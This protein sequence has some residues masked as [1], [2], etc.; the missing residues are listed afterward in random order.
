MSFELVYIPKDYPNEFF[1]KIAP[2]PVEARQARGLNNQV[3]PALKFCDKLDNQVV[4]TGLD[5]ARGALGFP[6]CN[7]DRMEPRLYRRDLEREGI[8]QIF[9]VD[10]RNGLAQRLKRFAGA[11]V[12]NF[13]GVEMIQPTLIHRNGHKQFFIGEHYFHAHQ[14]NYT[15]LFEQIRQVIRGNPLTRTNNRTEINHS[16]S[17][18]RIWVWNQGIVPRAAINDSNDNWWLDRVQLGMTDYVI[19]LNDHEFESDRLNLISAYRDSDNSTLWGNLIKVLNTLSTK[20]VA[21]HLMVFFPP[22]PNLIEHAAE[23]L[24]EILQLSPVTPRSIQLDLEGWW[25]RQS[26]SSRRAGEGAI[27]EYFYN[28]WN[29]PRPEL[30]IGITHIA[31]TPASIHGALSEV[32]F[33]IPQMYASQ[34]NYGRPV[35]SSTVEHHYA[36]ASETIGAGKRVIVGQTA[37]QQYVTPQ[38]IRDMLGIILGI[39]TNHSIEISFWSDKHILRNENISQYFT[40]LTRIAKTEGIDSN[41]LPTP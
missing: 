20:G 13:R 25:T 5:F 19:A 2:P 9:L 4:L 37:N 3:P 18:D 30:G 12:V 15:Q 10:D 21:P 6:R 40:R 22:Q 33:S 38:V 8:S 17:I 11:A 27:R 24:Q 41:N 7:G 26:N 32:D 14:L 29:G 28:S 39:S 36:R 35:R 31:S 34:R 23:Q 16:N 1:V